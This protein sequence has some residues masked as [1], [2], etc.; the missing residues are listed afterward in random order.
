MSHVSVYHQDEVVV[1]RKI[2]GEEGISYIAVDLAD[3]GEDKDKRD[4]EVSYRKINAA[5]FCAGV[6]VDEGID[7]LIKAVPAFE[8]RASFKNV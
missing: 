1:F 8:H 6:G 2:T 5:G 7:Q 3:I 4:Y